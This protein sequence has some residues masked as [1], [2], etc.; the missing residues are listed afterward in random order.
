MDLICQT[1]SYEEWENKSYSMV[2]CLKGALRPMPLSR[3]EVGHITRESIVV[4]GREDY[5]H[6]IVCLRRKYTVSALH[7]HRSAR[8]ILWP[9]VR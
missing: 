2:S 3:E 5:N 4:V 9:C 8:F 1:H 7:G 6:Y